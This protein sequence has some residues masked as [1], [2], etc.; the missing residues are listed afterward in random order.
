[1]ITHV[2]AF[3]LKPMAE[4]QEQALLDAFN[5]LMGVVPELEAFHMGRNVS[6]RDQ[7]YTHALVGRMADM[8]AVGRYL[9]HPAHVAVVKDH[10]EP[11]MLE[12]HILDF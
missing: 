11:V 3:K 8:E 1:M 12:R 6:D 4:A 10:L 7:T 5:G 9:R 2:V